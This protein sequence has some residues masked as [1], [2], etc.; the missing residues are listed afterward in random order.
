MADLGIRLTMRNNG[1]LPFN[2][3]WIV[4]GIPEATDYW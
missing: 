3:F 1:T 2:N 4:Q